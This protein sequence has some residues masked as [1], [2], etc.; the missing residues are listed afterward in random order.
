MK[1]KIIGILATVALALFTWISS[2]SFAESETQN[3]TVPSDQGM[4][5]PCGQGR[6]MEPCGQGRGMGY[7]RGMHSGQNRSGNQ[8][9]IVDDTRQFVELPEMARKIMRQ[10]MLNNLTAL[11]QILGLLAEGK[12]KEAADIAE[13]QIGNWRIGGGT[14][15]GPGKFMPVGMRQIGQ[16]MHSSVEEFARVARAGE[17]TK[18]YAALQNVTAICVACHSS[19]RTR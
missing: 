15:M 11:T 9:P 16:S 7:G 1:H 18:A 2:N 14:G 19:Y 12:L 5:Q 3:A 13:T 8:I 17:T 10:R 4:G 6:E